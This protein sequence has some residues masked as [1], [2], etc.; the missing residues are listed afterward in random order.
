[1]K[2]LADHLEG[3]APVAR[4]NCLDGQPLR[5]DLEDQIGRGLPGQPDARAGGNGRPVLRDVEAQLVMADVSV[6]P[7]HGMVQRALDRDGKATRGRVEQTRQGAPR[8]GDFDLVE[9]LVVPDEREDLLG[10]RA[11]FGIGDRRFRRPQ[12]VQVGLRHA[13]TRREDR[14]EEPGE[15]MSG[16]ASSRRRGVGPRKVRRSGCRERSGSSENASHRS[17]VVSALSR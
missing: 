9:L 3:H 7:R 2:P 12:A 4:P 6:R 16:R 15:R 11:A 1:M 10:E 14:S 8:R 13:G 17:G 5:R